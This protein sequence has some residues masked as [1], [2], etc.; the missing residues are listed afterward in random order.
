MKKQFL[1]LTFLL[2]NTTL[3]FAQAPSEKELIQLSLEKWQWMSDKNVEKLK[4]LFDD[5]AKFVH[6]SGTWK[7]EEE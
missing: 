3:S 1:L 4:D 6:M 7:K 5:K 2:L